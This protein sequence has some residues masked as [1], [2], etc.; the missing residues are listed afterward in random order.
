MRRLLALIVVAIVIASGAIVWEYRNRGEKPQRPDLWGLT[1]PPAAGNLTWSGEGVQVAEESID[2]AARFYGEFEA[3]LLDLGYS[4]LMGN[5]SSVS[6]QWSVWDNPVF[7][8]TYYIAYSGRRFLSI[9]GREEEVLRA[10]GSRWLC[11]NPSNA[12]TLLTPSPQREAVALSLKLGALFS[13]RGI[14]V[15]NAEWRGPLPDWYLGKFS[16]RAEVGG[17]VDLLILVYTK[18]DQAEYA[19]YELKKAD[20]GLRILRSYGLRYHALIVLNG[21]PEDVK[22]AV[23]ILQNFEDVG[24]SPRARG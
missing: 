4:M 22:R 18:E 16:F 10:A 5:W 23:A 15:R 20:H 21:S 17:G 7:N 3:E 14:A 2:N 13:N 6:C 9:R 19:A 1:D 11:Q 8:R 12:S 24:R